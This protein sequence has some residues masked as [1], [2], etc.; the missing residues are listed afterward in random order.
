MEIR[1]YKCTQKSLVGYYLQADWNELENFINNKEGVLCRESKGECI[2]Q[3][4]FKFDKI[5]KLS[6]R[7]FIIQNSNMSIWCKS[8]KKIPDF[9]FGDR[10]FVIRRDKKT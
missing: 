7:K 4:T 10:S 6:E 3:Y 2:D 8:N 1:V 9:A 5:I